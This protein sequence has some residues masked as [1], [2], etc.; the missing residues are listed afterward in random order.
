M[1]DLS[2]LLKSNRQRKSD[3]FRELFLVVAVR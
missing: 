1:N 2:A 3:D